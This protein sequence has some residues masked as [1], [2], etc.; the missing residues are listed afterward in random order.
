MDIK[1]L[2]Y[3]K[4]E[5]SGEMISPNDHG[6]V[7]FGNDKIATDDIET[8]LIENPAGYSKPEIGVDTVCMFLVSGGEKR[9]R[10]YIKYLESTA[11]RRMRVVFISK[12]GQG[13]TP[14]Q[15]LKEVEEAIDEGCF[16]D[17]YGH[18]TY[19]S[20]G[21]AIYL[22]SD[23][24]QYGVE[25]E[26]HLGNQSGNYQWIISNPA[27]E[28]WLYYHYYD[29]PEHIEDA[30]KITI[31]K[32]SQWLKDKLHRL[33][34]ADGGVNASEALKLMETAIVNSRKNYS[35]ANNKIPTLFSTQMHIV[36]EHILRLMEDDFYVMIKD[37]NSMAEEFMSETV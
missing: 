34:E 21:D 9:E 26:E 8:V 12:K 23:V 25:L 24:D 13:L 16:Q 2:D 32:R 5:P 31:D 4:S 28:V 27:F 14:T 36:A 20:E 33:R 15:M 10:G 22:I 19:L 11:S 3:T 29:S 37:R 30:I 7:S 1:D 6:L 18:L 35:I 17:Y